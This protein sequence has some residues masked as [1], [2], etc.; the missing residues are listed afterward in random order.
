MC[1]VVDNEDFSRKGKDRIPHFNISSAEFHIV[2]FLDFG[3]DE[4][5]FVSHFEIYFFIYHYSWSMVQTI[6]SGAIVIMGNLTARFIC[7]S[8]LVVQNNE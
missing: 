8:C 3:F 4:E 2:T 1:Y 7:K 6:I 5:V